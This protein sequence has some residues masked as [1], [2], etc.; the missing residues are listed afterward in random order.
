MRSFLILSAVASCSSTLL[1]HRNIKLP[2][3]SKTGTNNVDDIEFLVRTLPEVVCTAAV[4][5]NLDNA[6]IPCE[7]D[8]TRCRDATKYNSPLLTCA[9]SSETSMNLFLTTDNFGG[10]TYFELSSSDG[11]RDQVG[12]REFS[13]KTSFHI[14]AC[15]PSDLCYNFTMADLSRDGMCCSPSGSYSGY[16]LIVNGSTVAADG[17]FGFSHTTLF[18]NCTQTNIASLAGSPFPTTTSTANPSTLQPTTRQPISKPPTSSP[19]TMTPVTLSPTTRKPTSKAPTVFP[20]ALVTLSPTT[21]KPVSKAPT[22]SPILAVTSSPTAMKPISLSPSAQALQLSAVTLQPVI[23]STK[24]PTKS[25]TGKLVSSTTPFSSSDLVSSSTNSTSNNTINST[26]TQESSVTASPAFVVLT[27]LAGGLLI[28]LSVLSVYRGEK[29]R[30]VTSGDHADGAFVDPELVHN[31]L[32]DHSSLDSI[33]CANE[34]ASR[35]VESAGLIC[36]QTKEGDGIEVSMSEETATAWAVAKNTSEA[37]D[38]TSPRVNRMDSLIESSRLALN[39]AWPRDAYTKDGELLA[40]TKKRNREGLFKFL[41]RSSPCPDHSNAPSEDLES[42]RTSTSFNEQEEKYDRH[43]PGDLPPLSLPQLS[44]EENRT[45]VGAAPLTH[46]D[47][48]LVHCIRNDEFSGG[49]EIEKR[50]KADTGGFEKNGEVDIADEAVLDVAKSKCKK[51]R[52]SWA[53]GVSLPQSLLVEANTDGNK[54]S[55]AE[56]KEDGFST[57][58]FYPPIDVEDI[59]PDEILKPTS[60]ILKISVDETTSELSNDRPL[61]GAT[62]RISVDE[63]SFANP[64][65]SYHETSERDG[66][67]AELS[68]AIFTGEADG[69]SNIEKTHAESEDGKVVG[70]KSWSKALPIFK[71]SSIMRSL[72]GKTAAI[73]KKDKS[74][75]KR[76]PPPPPPL[77]APPPSPSSKSELAF[78]CQN[79]NEIEVGKEGVCGIGLIS[80]VEDGH[81]LATI[82]RHQE[83]GFATFVVD[84]AGNKEKE[85]PLPPQ[86]HVLPH[87]PSRKSVLAVFSLNNNEI[88]VS[89]EGIREKKLIS[90]FEDGPKLATIRRHQE[91]GFATFVFET[92]GKKEKDTIEL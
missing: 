36:K 91:D 92:A 72:S 10:E 33:T 75:P 52:V 26:L 48:L 32:T 3:V 79:N 39:Y 84:T 86:L 45:Q 70:I 90:T 68:A 17:A 61:V 59:P 12:P 64:L 71:S 22:T 37:V 53:K 46:D 7:F 31:D 69:E 73:R 85:K 83:D 5:R 44:Q 63:K 78:F 11:A 2:F 38:S 4:C 76:R 43:Y 65:I 13:D 8:L 47:G 24:A 23:T 60:G 28:S 15:L 88:E 62:A 30:V 42:G 18:G 80:T 81:K 55:Y 89:K 82:C 25:P 29:T 77:H 57:F 49:L 1:K 58:L 67:E 6:K 51:K 41:F 87:S 16:E 21:M 35:P 19:I 40:S 54:S 66:V 56:K 34:E 20:V 9:S 14:S 50:F 74:K 27:V